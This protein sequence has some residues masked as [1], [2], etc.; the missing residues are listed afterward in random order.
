MKKC[1]RTLT[2]LVGLGMRSEGNAMKK[3]EPIVG[4]SFSTMLQHTGLFWARISQQRTLWQQ[5][6][7]PH[8]LLTRLQLIFTC[9]LDWNQ[10]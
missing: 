7:A 1:T 6:S 5:W 9:S 2:S 10:Y 4:F 8:T 3:G